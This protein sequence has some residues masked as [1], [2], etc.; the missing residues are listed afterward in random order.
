[1]SKCSRHHHELCRGTAKHSAVRCA[2]CS[3][4]L[5][6][7][8]NDPAVT[9]I[10]LDAARGVAGADHVLSGR[11]SMGAE[12]FADYDLGSR[13]H[14]QARGEANGKENYALAYLDVRY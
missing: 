6:G 2:S 9:A 10:C 1:M 8:V 3:M 11:P 4:Q 12:D 14:D 7:V 5:P 13:L